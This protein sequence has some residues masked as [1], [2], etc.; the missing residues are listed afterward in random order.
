[1][2]SRARLRRLSCETCEEKR[3]EKKLMIYRPGRKRSRA[4]T[5]NSKHPMP[6]LEYAAERPVVSRETPCISKKRCAVQCSATLGGR[7]RRIRI[8]NITPEGGVF[9]VQSNMPMHRVFSHWVAAT[10][11]CRWK[12]HA[13]FWHSLLQYLVRRQRRHLAN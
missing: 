8:I 10:H 4:I 7:G 2:V 6:N 1:M 3:V 9:R 5:I 12:A 11:Q 13:L